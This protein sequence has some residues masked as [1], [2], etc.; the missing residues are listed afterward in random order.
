MAENTKIQWADHT[1]NP[2]I[3]CTKVSSGCEN[4]YAEELMDSRFG[5]VQWG[6]QGTRV[7]TSAANWS[8]PRK[9]NLEAEKSGVRPRVFCASLADVFED[10]NEL[11]AWRRELF[12][13]IDDCIYLDWLLLTKR[14]ENI[15]PLTPSHDKEFR[16]NVWLGTSVE[17][18]QAAD[19][20][21]PHLLS[22][23]ACLRFLSCEPLLRSVNLECVR[24]SDDIVDYNSLEG[25]GTSKKSCCQSIPN[26]TGRKIDWVI[27]GGESGNSARECVISQVTSIVNQCRCAGTPVFVKQLGA[28][29]R[30]AYGG[31]IRLNGKKGDDLDEFPQHLRVRQ[32][33][34]LVK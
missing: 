26:V 9:W 30:S 16:P 15:S 24:I 7:K 5:K 33:P 10:R 8:K 31:I 11:I 22:V 14:P 4:C 1:F 34:E 21:I 6:P 2:W 19:A 13:L 20:R 28:K 17:D 32:F 29:P 25:C 27:V 12:G 3:G 23:P 18:Q